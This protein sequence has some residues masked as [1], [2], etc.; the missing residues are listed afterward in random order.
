[1]NGSY[2]VIV[3]GAGPAGEHC[4]GHL[5]DGGL[6]VAIVERELLGGECDYWACIPSKTLLRPGEALQAAREAPGAREAVGGD[7]DAGSAFEWRNF[8]TSNWDDTAKEEWPRSKGMDI[9]R[10]E[11]TIT[12]PG[13]VAVDGAEHSCEHIV[14][15]TGS[16]PVIPP[17]DGLRELEGIWTNREVTAMT[18]VPKRLVVLGGGPVGAEMAQ[19]CMR[20]G[21]S[22]VAL[23]EGM[24]HL[25]PREPKALGD[26][27]GQALSREGLELHFGQH[28][29]AA[30]K[31]GDHYVLEFPDGSELRGDRLLV[32]TGR[33]PRMEGLGLENVDVEAGKRGIEVDGRM[34]AA[35]GVWAVGDVTGI[36]PLTYV[37]KY[38]GRVAAANILGRERQANYDAVPRVVF[39]DPQAASVGAAEGEVEVSV[40]ITSTARL[41]TYTREY[42]EKIGFLT[43]VSDGRRLIG[44]YALGPEAGEWLQ[45]ATLA[46]RAEVPLEVVAD[47]IQPFP[48][49]SEIFLFALTELGTKVPAAAAA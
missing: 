19:A 25:L 41:S 17:I 35:D 47:T 33:T 39:T 36:W 5:A 22:S 6:K 26:A 42:D 23:V 28:A 49:F 10:G 31:D 48:S 40:P 34:K 1:M 12:G 14:V 3:I 18:E 2:D 13:R 43:L 30:H 16:D 44:A 20:L 45:Q 9:L 4:A 15:A 11:G 37:G 21:S 7:I 32:A 8:M 29:S 46:I 27:L 24:D 38:Q